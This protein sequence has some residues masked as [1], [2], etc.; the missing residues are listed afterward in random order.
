[1]PNHFDPILFY[2]K[3]TGRQYGMVIDIENGREWRTLLDCMH[4]VCHSRDQLRNNQVEPINRILTDIWLDQQQTKFD[5]AIEHFF[6]YRNI[7]I[8][9][10][11]DSE[12]DH[13]QL[14]LLPLTLQHINDHH[15]DH[16]NNNNNNN[17][18]SVVLYTN[19]NHINIATP[20]VTVVDTA[21]NSEYSTPPS[22]PPNLKPA[23][24]ILMIT[25]VTDDNYSTS[26]RYA[27]RDH[28]MSHI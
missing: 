26:N 4:R 2:D 1:M 5:K 19:N 25:T 16:N 24:T 27:P 22:T 7:E 17:N 11:D 3:S 12:S 20:D 21:L 14:Q 9:L 28:P 8:D 6:T 10:T 23:N 13:H 18:H 15:H